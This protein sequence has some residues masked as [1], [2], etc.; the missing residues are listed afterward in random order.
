MIKSH[1]AEPDISPFL[2][3]TFFFLFLF[4]RLHYLALPDI[5]GHYL[6]D[7]MQLPLL[8]TNLSNMQ[9]QSPRPINTLQC[10]KSVEFVFK[11]SQTRANCL[12]THW[13]DKQ[14]AQ[15]SG[16]KKKIGV[17]LTININDRCFPYV[18]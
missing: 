16:L 4:W 6:S 18:K 13:R 11:P 9:Q 15:F 2:F 10:V 12:K 14:E 1:T 5:A 3:H 17:K 8:H 7:Y